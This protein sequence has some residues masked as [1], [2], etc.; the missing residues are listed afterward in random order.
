MERLKG[1]R[2]PDGILILADN[3]T[4]QTIEGFPQMQAYGRSR[5]VPCLAVF[6]EELRARVDS[7]IR[8]TKYGATEFQP[9]TLRTIRTHFE[10]I[11]R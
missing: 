1:N 8:S 10:S 6:P 7:A 5:K 2:P 3:C 9:A 4:D 11:G